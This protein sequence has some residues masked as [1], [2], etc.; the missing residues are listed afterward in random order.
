MFHDEELSIT[1]QYSDLGFYPLCASLCPPALPPVS[2]YHQGA[3]SLRL[4]SSSICLLSPSQS[5]SDLLPPPRH[6]STPLA[7]RPSR[8]CQLLRKPPLQPRQRGVR[9]G[10]DGKVYRVDRCWGGGG[11]GG[12]C[13]QRAGRRMNLGLAAPPF[14]KRA[15]TQA[16]TLPG[17]PIAC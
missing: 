10:G 1:L 6:P 14:P 8:N 13:S 11:G 15:I 17:H 5:S 2:F 3:S 9:E 4:I 12:A 16:I 7:L